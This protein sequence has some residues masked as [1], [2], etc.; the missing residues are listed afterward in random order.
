[1][2]HPV[3]HEALDAAQ[4]KQQ[5]LTAAAKARQMSEGEIPQRDSSSTEPTMKRFM[6]RGVPYSALND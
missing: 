5:L 2:Q 4:Q 6:L 3:T 1:M